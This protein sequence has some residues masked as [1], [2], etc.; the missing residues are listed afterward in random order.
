MT[1]IINSGNANAYPIITFRGPGD[2]V[3]IAN[4]RTSDI[5]NFQYTMLPF[6]T[7]IVDTTIG[8]KTVTSSLTGNLLLSGGVQPS[9]LGSFVLLPDDNNVNILILNKTVDTRVTISFQEEYL[10]FDG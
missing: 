1:L 3:A 9:D 4:N 6:E 7:V 5:I 10:S 2:I 8:F